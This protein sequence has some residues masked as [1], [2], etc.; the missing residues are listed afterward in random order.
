MFYSHF[1]ES[2]WDLRSEI[3]IIFEHL[4]LKH[5]IEVPWDFLPI[6]ETTFQII[7]DFSNVWHMHV[8]LRLIVLS[9]KLE[10]DLVCQE[11][12]HNELHYFGIFFILEM[13]IEEHAHASTDH[14]LAPGFVLVNCQNR[15]VAGIGHGPW[16][17][18][19][20]G[21]VHNSQSTPID[22]HKITAQPFCLLLIILFI[23]ISAPEVE[24]VIIL[25]LLLVPVIDDSCDF[26][27][28]HSVVDIGLFGV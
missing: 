1:V 23:I 10:L 14:E 18:N 21:R 17:Q 6:L 8:L 2:I 27:I 11:K 5:F 15:S 25:F 7:W 22:I 3:E 4:E 24:H 28:E 16:A 26:F 13:V 20:V 9:A 12:F 19:R